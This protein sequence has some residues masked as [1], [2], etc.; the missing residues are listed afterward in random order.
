MGQSFGTVSNVFYAVL[1]G[2][3]LLN[4]FYMAA[5]VAAIALLLPR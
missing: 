3:V 1:L 5:G 2:T 4:V